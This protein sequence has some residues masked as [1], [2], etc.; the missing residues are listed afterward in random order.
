MNKPFGRKVVAFRN[1]N[2]LIAFLLL[3]YQSMNA[4][5]DSAKEG[6]AFAEQLHGQGYRNQENVINEMQQGCGQQPQ[7]QHSE[8]QACELKTLFDGHYDN[9][10]KED[11]LK[12]HFAQKN[13]EAVQHKHPNQPALGDAEKLLK[14][15]HRFHISA[16]SDVFKNYEAI[17]KAVVDDKSQAELFEKGSK[18]VQPK[19]PLE[20]K[21]VTCR[22]GVPPELQTCVKTLIVKAVPQ[23]DLI[24][25][26]TAHFTA[27]CY[28]LVTFSINLKTGKIDVSQCENAGPTNLSV[29]HPIGEPDYPARTTIPNFNFLKP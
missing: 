2:R 29:D 9:G 11:V 24:K 26:V 18:P 16:E 23:E 15:K 25:T 1:A 22:K 21:I 10:D 5:A 13:T 17:T 8:A 4:M 3:S 14:E 20:D 6:K 27:Q 7:N 19:S 12:S 28:N